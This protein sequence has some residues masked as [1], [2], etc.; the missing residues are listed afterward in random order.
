M[1]NT[2]KPKGRDEWGLHDRISLVPPVGYETGEKDV[3]LFQSGFC[4]PSDSSS[5]WASLL[6]LSEDTVPTWLT[7]ALIPALRLSLLCLQ[8]LHATHL[9]SKWEERRSRGLHRRVCSGKEI[10]SPL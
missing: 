1:L 6:S 7:C 4:W 8:L 9:C 3:G 10:S 2:E 5:P